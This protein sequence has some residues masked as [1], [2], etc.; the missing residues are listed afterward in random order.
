MVDQTNAAISGRLL[1]EMADRKEI[2][3]VPDRYCA[4]YETLDAE[5]VRQL[6]P[7]ATLSVLRSQLEP[8]KSLK[9]TVMS[10]PIFLRFDGS[11][12]GSATITFK[13]RHVAE[14]KADGPPKTNDIAVTMALSRRERGT[15]WQIVRIEHQPVEAR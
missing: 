1:A 14:M 3:A 5:R 13:I 4:A 6:I 10:P 7:F 12:P 2:G 8:Y 9:C 15:P 11:E